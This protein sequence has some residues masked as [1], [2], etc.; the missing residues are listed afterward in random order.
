MN[1]ISMMQ[2]IF[3]IANSMVG[4]TSLPNFLRST[5]DAPE[6]MRVRAFDQLNGPLDGDIDRGSQ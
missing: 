4:E 5:E 3:L 1:V 6:F 2:E